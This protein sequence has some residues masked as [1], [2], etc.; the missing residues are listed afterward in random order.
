MDFDIR[1]VSLAPSVSFDA[2]RT[3]SDLLGKEVQF[4]AG[5]SIAMTLPDDPAAFDCLPEPDRLATALDSWA[6]VYDYPQGQDRVRYILAPA[7][8]P[9]A[10]GE[11]LFHRLDFLQ[12]ARIKPGPRP[13]VEILGGA[14]MTYDECANWLAEL[15]F[16]QA[17]V[18]GT[19][20]QRPRL[21]KPPQVRIA[22]VGPELLSGES[23][24]ARLRALGT[25]MGA[26]IIH[27]GPQSFAHVKARLAGFSP[28]HAVALC[29]GTATYITGDVAPKTLSPTAIHYCSGTNPSEVYAE[30]ITIIHK[31]RHID[32][33]DRREAREEAE[34]L[35]LML[36]GM[37]S[38]SKIGPF[39]HCTRETVLTGV[40][41]RRLNVPAADALLDRHS[42]VH[43][44]TKTSEKLFLWK[45]HNDGRQYFL[46]PKKIE[47]VKVLIA[48][49]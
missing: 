18:K 31:S 22:W 14:V 46:N 40:R 42:E 32:Q 25:V 49:G 30:L 35:G 5:L 1:A 2:R 41:A 23:M 45:D 34:L 17:Q 6:R 7:E 15:S 3:V 13:P 26:E 11:L 16:T 9:A 20:L 4:R 37:M 44:D 43:Q 39:N 21:V 29:I 12:P 24:P 27:I 36:R 38:H 19:V 28:L 47:R 33:E 8:N 10:D 48:T